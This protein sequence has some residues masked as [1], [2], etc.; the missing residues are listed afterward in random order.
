MVNNYQDLLVCAGGQISLVSFTASSS[1]ATPWFVQPRQSS[2]VCSG[3]M[4]LTSGTLLAS[5]SR[6]YS[7]DVTGVYVFNAS[8]GNLTWQEIPSV[9]H[10]S[11]RELVPRN[12]RTDSFL[13]RVPFLE[14]PPSVK[15]GW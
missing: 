3:L 15:A 10:A 7:S 14:L 13:A 2:G 8:T 11:S 12:E 5:F 9:A 4:W 1:S 6:Y